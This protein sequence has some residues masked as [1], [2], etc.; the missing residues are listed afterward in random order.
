MVLKAHGDPQSKERSGKQRGVTKEKNTE[1]PSQ[2]GSRGTHTCSGLDP[3][4][5]VVY[6]E[7]PAQS[8]SMK[9]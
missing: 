8:L 4:L 2:K 6:V 9:S 3:D 7:T 5:N 1:C